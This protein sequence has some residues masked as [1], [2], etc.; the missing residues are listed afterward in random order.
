MIA[1]PLLWFL[2]HRLWDLSDAPDIG[3]S[4]HDAWHNGYVTANRRLAAAVVDELGDAA[5]GANVL[6]QDYHLYLVPGLIRRV[7]PDVT[8]R[9]FCHIPWP[10]S[11]A[12]RVL[13]DEWRRAIFEGLLGADIVGFQ[14]EENAHNFVVGCAELLD[15]D[16]DLDHLQVHYDGRTIACR[17]YPVS[18]DAD[19]FEELAA[20]PHVHEHEQTLI[21][22]RREYLVVRVDRT[23]LSKNI[24]RGF[25]AFDLL[26]DE[27]PELRERIT[28]LALLQPSRQD[29]NEYVVYLEKIKRTVADLNLKHGK[30]DWQPIDLHFVDDL[31]LAVAAYKQYDALMVNAIAD[32]MNLVAKEGPLVNRRDGV[33]LLSE[34]TGAH[35]ELGRFAV[36]V[37]PFDVTQ[38][39]D[40]LWQA[41]TMPREQRRARREACAEIVRRNSLQR[42]MAVQ[43]EDRR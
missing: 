24:L 4:E 15:L 13:P 16:V 8:L 17:W 27:H 3:P 37:H 22:N 11:H 19:Q 33:L 32:G 2:Q 12:W 1:N 25:R 35:A 5:D 43:L 36:S 40:A 14:T 23:D 28:F 26:L 10:Q 18:V 42:W 34:T 38:Q 30:A 29:V 39:A 7:R 9:F 21:A 20:S 6:I 41:L 31:D